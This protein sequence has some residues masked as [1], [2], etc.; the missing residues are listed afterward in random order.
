MKCSIAMKNHSTT[1]L[2]IAC[3]T[4]F[5]WPAGEVKAQVR[6]NCSEI[7]YY[8][9]SATSGVYT[10]DPDGEGSLPAMD[11]RCDMTTDG[12]GWT[13]VLNYNHL[14]NTN[15]ALSV[16]TGSL[17]LQGET[18]LGFDESGTAYWG[19]AGNGLMTALPFDEVR[20]YGYTS[21]HARVIHF[22]T[23]HGGTVSYFK[24]G[25]GSTDGISTDFTPLTGHTSMLPAAINMT[26]SNMGDYAMTAYPLWTGSTY[27]WYLGGEDPVCL[28]R[29]EVDNYPCT[30]PSTFHQIWVRQNVSLGVN[31]FIHGTIELKLSPNP[32]SVNA[33]LTVVNA[34]QRQ[35]EKAR[36]AFYNMTGIQVFPVITGRNGK[37]TIDKGGLAPGIYLC[38]LVNENGILAETRMIVH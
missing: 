12:G 4:L 32:L 30:T 20:F 25:T 19:H 8:N 11:C 29:W 10:I 1:A 23:S 6:R 28:R 35:L 14:D 17:P 15:P 9:P 34:S 26:V 27:H 21:D 2:V 31:D 37:Y 7:L 33:E 36:I 18:A 38:R 24:S 22:K 5:W 3:F 13:L 16:L